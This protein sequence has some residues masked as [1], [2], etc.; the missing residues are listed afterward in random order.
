MFSK[1]KVYF[2][3]VLTFDTELEMTITQNTT[4]MQLFNQVCD[5]IGLREVWYFGMQYLNDQNELV[6]LDLLKKVS[7]QLDQPKGSMVFYF[8]AKYFPEDATDELICEATVNLFYLQVKESILSEEIQCPLETSILLASYACQAKFGDYNE[9]IMVP[10]FLFREPLI[11]PGLRQRSGMSLVELEQA[12]VHW[13]RQHRNMLRWDAM[14][15]YLHI[16]QDLE[17]YGVTYFEIRNKKGSNLLLGVDQFGLN[18]YTADNRRIP[19][20]SFPWSEIANV[21]YKRL[22]FI[23]TSVD[24]TSEKLI[25]YA[26]RVEHNQRLLSLCVGAHEMYIRR[27][28]PESIE[29]Q[30]MRAQAKAE[31]ES[32]SL[33]R[34]RLLN[35][36][37]AQEDAEC[38]LKQ[39][40]ARLQ[41]DASERER[42]RKKA[43]E[44]TKR[45]SELEAQLST[46][47]RLREQ[48]EAARKRMELKNSEFRTP[49]TESEEQRMRLLKEKNVIQEE[50]DKLNHSVRDSSKLIE[51]TRAQLATIGA[52]AQP[53]SEKRNTLRTNGH[54]LAESV[55][56]DSID[57]PRLPT[58]PRPRSE[59][60]I[61]QLGISATDICPKNTNNNAKKATAR[62][63]VATTNNNIG[64]DRNY[65]EGEGS[66]NDNNKNNDDGG[67]SLKCT[68]LPISPVE[69][70]NQPPIERQNN[71]TLLNNNDSSFSASQQPSS[72]SETYRIKDQSVSEQ[73]NSDHLLSSVASS[74]SSSL[75]S[76]N[77]A[78]SIPGSPPKS[79]GSVLESINLNT[80][81]Q[82]ENLRLSN[83]PQ[84]DDDQKLMIVKRILSQSADSGESSSRRAQR[85]DT[86]T[87]ECKELCFDLNYLC[88]VHPDNRMEQI[89]ENKQNSTNSKV[90]RDSR[91]I[92]FNN[93]AWGSSAPTA[94]NRYSMYT[95]SSK[96]DQPMD[97]EQDQGAV[98]PYS[99]NFGESAPRYPTLHHVR[100]GNTKRRV[101]EFESI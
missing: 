66:N 60:L 46:E 68:V 98:R 92:D 95:Q 85:S 7:K 33:D 94:S 90:D 45:I 24:K 20:M 80:T 78:L 70:E 14:I 16:A 3:K 30:H 21:T 52:N 42:I 96:Y 11:S 35:A 6:W 51:V 74:S 79:T 44:L 97:A 99:Y 65:K 88:S 28:Q 82:M 76:P 29:L 9:K 63:A 2:V 47:T 72:I 59:M 100:R 36:L 53:I 54:A 38:Q 17:M 58:N 49:D 93:D 13:Y 37:R 48:L 12:V 5:T 91:S 25:F 64:S 83:D 31:R 40:S 10:G 22:K 34:E 41:E 69:D 27:S 55:G 86:S 8:R 81:Q 67:P 19:K 89:N 61:S 77:T 50:I 39:L 32:K 84:P 87:E 43:E 73:L 26:T 1:H 75:S 62:V 101:E 4:G 18:V 15:E 57:Y 56:P 23:V 71:A